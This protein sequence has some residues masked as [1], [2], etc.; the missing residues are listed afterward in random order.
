MDILKE[1][2]FLKF[3]CEILRLSFYLYTPV[4]VKKMKEYEEAKETIRSR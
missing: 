3:L 2:G 4:I 1:E